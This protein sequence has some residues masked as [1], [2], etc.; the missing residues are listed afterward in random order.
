MFSRR[1][2]RKGCTQ[3]CPLLAGPSRVLPSAAVQRAGSVGRAWRAP[4]GGRG[5]EPAEGQ[6][7]LVVVE[8][9]TCASSCP[10]DGET[11]AR[12][13]A[14]PCLGGAR[15]RPRCARGYRG[16][17]PVQ[18]CSVPTHRPRLQLRSGRR[19][20]GGGRWLQRRRG[21]AGSRAWGAGSLS[22]SHRGNSPTAG[23]G[24]AGSAQRRERKCVTGA[25]SLG[26]R[27][28]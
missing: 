25:G 13:G 24:V 4:G 6:T 14:R 9:G 23:S 7:V 15:H 2:P 1:Y 10:A 18:A 11:E 27:E 16:S 19:G 28:K 3:V 26:T 21:R 5:P 8:V 20:G 17:A 22:R 12:G